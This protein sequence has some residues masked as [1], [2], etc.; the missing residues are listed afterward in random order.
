MAAARRSSHGLK[1]KVIAAQTLT[2]CPVQYA[3][4]I[5]VLKMLV[6]TQ[7]LLVV[8]QCQENSILVSIKKNYLFSIL[9]TINEY[10]CWSSVFFQVMDLGKLKVK[11]V[12][13]KN[14]AIFQTQ[15]KLKWPA[16]MTKNVTRYMTLDVED[17]GYFI[18]ALLIRL[19][20]QNNPV[21]IINFSS[22]SKLA[23]RTP[24]NIYLYI[25][26]IC[27]LRPN[28]LCLVFQIQIRVIKLNV[29]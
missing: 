28:N 5:I 17:Q 23:S 6:L 13:V 25:Y 29:A 1:T 16:K 11:N 19:H 22:V 12:K 4:R 3:G 2:A 14:M 21:F 8:S 7:E 18:Y 15:P 27:R 9:E 24:Y 26:D 10:V 20:T